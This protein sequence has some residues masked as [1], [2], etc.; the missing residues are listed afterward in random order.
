MYLLLILGSLLAAD[1]PPDPTKPGLVAL[2][3]KDR[4][5]QE[6]A[7]AIGSRSGSLVVMQFYN[8]NEPNPRKMTLIS[9]EPVPFWDAIDRFCR[10]AKL[11]R[12]FNEG[13][14][15]G[16]TQPNVSIYG[17]GPDPGPAVYSGPFRF[18]KFTIHSNY[19][20]QFSPDA[21]YTEPPIEGYRAEFE[22]LPEPRVMAVRT[23]P[24]KKLVAID[25]QD[26]SLLDP[27]V[28]DPEKLSGVLNNGTLGGFQSIVRVKLATPQPGSLKLKTLRGV[29]PVEVGIA[30]KVPTAVIPLADSV[31]KTKKIGDVAITVE[32]FSTRGGV[33]TTLKILAKLEG[34]RGAEGK[35][36]KPLVWARSGMI[37]R[38]LEIVDAEGRVLNAG[39]G[40][41]S[42]GDELRLN[43][44]FPSGGPGRMT[45]AP[46]TLRVYS[47]EWVR[48]DAPFEF[49]DVPLP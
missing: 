28:T 34:P 48:W 10:D 9:P 23:G 44:T 37:Q 16:R 6:I 35:A 32:E 21:K 43:Y 27:N 22:V 42:S 45:S 17:P 39:S 36:A 46:K 29:M 31:G 15:L 20:K 19:R 11:Q 40:G 13:S 12:T 49:H 14:G 38:T 33:G 1:P 41:S 47:P 25:D 7:L 30:P 8:E 24:L 4:P 18:G 2:D 26:R 3:F 5:M